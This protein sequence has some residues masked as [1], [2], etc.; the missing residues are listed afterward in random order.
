MQKRLKSVTKIDFELRSTKNGTRVVTKE[1]ADF[2]AIKLH[3][4]TQNLQ[5]FTFYPK[6][7][8]PIKAVMRHLPPNTPAEDISY[9]LV[10]LGYDVIRV[11]QMST[12][13]RSSTEEPSSI[14]LP[15]FLITLPRKQSP[16]RALNLQ[17]SAIFQSR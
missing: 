5:Y 10:D 8:K 2:S 4:D 6:F 14:N 12:T 9:G 7:Q 1:M 3:F 11:K 15:I 13:R 16:M 17:A